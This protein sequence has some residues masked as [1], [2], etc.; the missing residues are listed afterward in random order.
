[1]SSAC[2][3]TFCTIKGTCD[4][5]ELTTETG[6]TAET[7]EDGGR[8]HLH[9]LP[10]LI[11]KFKLTLPDFYRNTWGVH[12]ILLQRIHVITCT[13]T[14]ALPHLLQYIEAAAS[15][16]LTLQ[17]AVEKVKRKGK[18]ERRRKQKIQYI[19]AVAWC[20][21]SVHLLGSVICKVG[22][23][24][25]C[26]TRQARSC[27]IKHPRSLP[28]IHT[29]RRMDREQQTAETLVLH[30]LPLIFGNMTLPLPV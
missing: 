19:L 24:Q 20:W 18:S 7:T 23:N 25:C 29:C 13:C 4:S 10:G 16:A 1:M 3:C 22:D 15:S 30:P 5:P 17:R 27:L 12:Y 2:L 9:F 6:P 26:C 11:S 21:W 14:T 28:L 8:V